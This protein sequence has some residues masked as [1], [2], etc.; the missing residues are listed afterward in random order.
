MKVVA[1]FTPR[2]VARQLRIFNQTASKFRQGY[3]A[4][5]VFDHN[6]FWDI[7]PRGGTL[8]VFDSTLVRHEVRVTNRN[9]R[10]LVGWFYEPIFAKG[11]TTRGQLPK[12][13]KPKKK[14]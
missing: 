12:K 14:R 4:F 5:D 10:A 13:T 1:R 6:A 11:A 3:K 9:R 8:V 7:E 2:L